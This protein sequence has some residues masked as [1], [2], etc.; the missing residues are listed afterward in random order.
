MTHYFRCNECHKLFLPSQV[1]PVVDL[2]TERGE[3]TTVV[4]DESRSFLPSTSLVTI[5]VSCHKDAEGR[6]W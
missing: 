5:C 2:V 3:E 6:G 4:G 1:P